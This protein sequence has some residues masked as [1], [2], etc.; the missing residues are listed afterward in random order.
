M[1][2]SRARVLNLLAI[3]VPLW[4]ALL[5][6][7]YTIRLPLFLDDGP[8]LWLVETIDGIEQ[9]RGASAF[10]YYRPVAFSIWKLSQTIMGGHHAAW[11][12]LLNVLERTGGRRGIAAIC[13]GGGQGGA[14]LIERV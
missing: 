6:Y 8:N 7:G 2:L 14:M 12:H 11:L 5:V 4:L 3:S 13:I 1:S 9:W 10:P